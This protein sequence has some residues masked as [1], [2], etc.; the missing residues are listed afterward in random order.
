MRAGEH[1][2]REDALKKARELDRYLW[3]AGFHRGWTA[4]KM[5]QPNGE[6]LALF[7]RRRAEV[8]AL[9]GES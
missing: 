4:G 5:K 2:D 8:D 1:V 9:I 3:L 6:V 7:E